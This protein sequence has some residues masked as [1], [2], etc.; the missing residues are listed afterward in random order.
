MS[1]LLDEANILARWLANKEG[2]TVER[3]AQSTLCLRTQW[4]QAWSLFN[5]EQLMERAQFACMGN[6][7]GWPKVCLGCQQL[8]KQKEKI[9]KYKLWG[10]FHFNIAF[11]CRKSKYPLRKRWN[12]SQYKFQDSFSPISSK[13]SI[14]VI[15]S[16]PKCTGSKNEF[17]LW[18]W[19]I[20]K[21]PRPSECSKRMFSRDSI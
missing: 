21:A 10:F 3:H 13:T 9:G 7:D 18:T 1:E 14:P 2:R 4:L 20:Q 15:I 16:P 5:L 11:G 19:N 12:R 8:V 6:D 17:Q